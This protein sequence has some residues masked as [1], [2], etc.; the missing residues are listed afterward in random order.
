MI[1]LFKNPNYDFIGKRKWAYIVSI[2]LTL[3]S[4]SSLAVRGRPS[5]SADTIVALAGSPIS[6]A[7]SAMMAPVI[8]SVI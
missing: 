8:I 1:E 4:L 7:I 2:A 5:R 6:A 3:I